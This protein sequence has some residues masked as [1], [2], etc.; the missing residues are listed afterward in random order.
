MQFLDNSLH[1]GRVWLANARASFVREMEFRS[2]FT[3][4]IIRQILWFGTFIVFIKALFAHTD[5]LAGWS[6]VEVLIVL[7]LSRVVEGIMS[8]FFIQNWMTFTRTVNR[9]EF[10][11]YL[12]RPVPVQFFTAFHH[13]NYHNIG[14]VLAGL[15]LLAYALWQQAY[16]PSWGEIVLFIVLILA[17]ITVYYSLLALVASLVFIM[18]RLESLWGFNALFSEPLTVPFDVFPGNARIA[19]TYLVP[20]AFV[21]FVPAQAL[22]GRLV[23]WQAPLAIGIAVLFLTLANLAWRAGLRRYSSASS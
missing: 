11:F 3:L 12:L 17:G 20:I 22:T 10:D 13:F 23:W 5:S 7:A 15:G 1:L 4:G 18:E 6:Q 8:T 9:G 21:V 14:N 19:L 16:V 2:N